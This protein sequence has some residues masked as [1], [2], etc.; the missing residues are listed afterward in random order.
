MCSLRNVA[1]LALLGAVVSL[2]TEQ[3]SRKEEFEPTPELKPKLDHE[4][5]KD[6][7]HD[8]KP[9]EPEPFKGLFPASQVDDHFDEDFVDDLNLDVNEHDLAQMDYDQI[10]YDMKLKR[11]AEAA[12]KKKSDEEQAEWQSAQKE[13]DEAKA[14]VAADRKKLDATVT[15]HQKKLRHL[16][17]AEM[18]DHERLEKASAAVDDA[19]HDYVAAKKILASTEKDAHELEEES[20]KAQKVLAKTKEELKEAKAVQKTKEE[21]HQRELANLEKVKKVHEEAQAKYEKELADVE[22]LKKD[23]KAAEARLRSFRNG[24]DGTF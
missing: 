18:S 22:Q 20:E 4:H 12:A 15:K 6:Y 9:E 13:L 16:K 14:K 19:H 23:F 17:K 7:K 1:F 11:E 3:K 5:W 2:E 24:G 8:D 21:N 10:R